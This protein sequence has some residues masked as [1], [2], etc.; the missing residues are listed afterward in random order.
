MRLRLRLRPPAIE[1]GQHVVRVEV[2]HDPE[3]TT[4][5]GTWNSHPD[6]AHGLMVVVPDAVTLWDLA[7]KLRAAAR[8]IDD[9]VEVRYDRDV[10]LRWANENPVA[11]R[12]RERPGELK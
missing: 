3:A 12:A 6:G 5:A 2:E 11:S 8:L 9:D 4:S 1:H 7:N 10:V